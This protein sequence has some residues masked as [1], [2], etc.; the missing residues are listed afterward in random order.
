MSREIQHNPVRFKKSL[1]IKIIVL[2]VFIC[3]LLI[4][5]YLWDFSSYFHPDNIQQL[6]TTA[7]SLAPLLF[8]AVMAAAV[9]ISPIPSLPLDIAA[10][11]FFGPFLGTLYAA[12]G[13]LGGSVISFMITRKL[14]RE[15]IEPFLGGHINFCK[16]CSD[17]LLTKVVF[18]SRLI[19]VVSFDIVSYGA[20]LTRMSLKKFCLAT[21]LGMLPLTFVYTYFGSTLVWDKGLGIIL[22]ILVVIMFF[23]IPRFIERFDLFSMRRV[24]QHTRPPRTPEDDN[25]ENPSP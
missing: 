13:A 15:L 19:P 11:A 14:G 17:K 20:G 3:S 16:E 4:A 24:F 2:A 10:G 21:F 6:L 1:A 18:L 9:V 23:M 22:G 7:G 8:M 12:L 5:E 25:R